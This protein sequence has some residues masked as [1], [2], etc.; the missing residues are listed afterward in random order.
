M[1]FVFLLHC[2]SVHIFDS[3]HKMLL[4]MRFL[5]LLYVFVESVSVV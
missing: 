5:V 4:E 3:T 2:S 1:T